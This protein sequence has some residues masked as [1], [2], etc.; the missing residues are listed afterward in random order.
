MGVGSM[1]YVFNGKETCDV[2]FD[3]KKNHYTIIDGIEKAISYIVDKHIRK[4]VEERLNKAF[5]ESETYRSEAELAL[6]VGKPYD[7]KDRCQKALEQLKNLSEQPLYADKDKNIVI[8]SVRCKTG[9][10][11][12]QPLRYNSKNEPI[13]FVLTK[14]NHHVAIY[15]D[16]RGEYKECIYSFWQVVERSKYKL[17]IIIKDPKALWDEIIH[18][19]KEGESFPDKLIQS[20]PSPK[21]V[22]VESLQLNDMFVMDMDDNIFDKY[23]ATKNY[24]ELGKKLYRVQKLSTFDYFF[25]LHTVTTSETTPEAALSK[26][27]IRIKSFKAYTEHNPHKVQISL[28]GKIIQNT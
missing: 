13:S 16:D 27:F 20:L 24:A 22:F 18:R 8:K 11:A 25:R 3:K 4:V 9:L 14:N 23:M 6:A 15:A 7:G 19:E 21:W 28:L 12:V 26:K 17:P 1:G 10:S 5:P 2:V